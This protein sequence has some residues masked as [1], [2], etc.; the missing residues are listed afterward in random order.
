MCGRRVPV[1]AV[2]TH[3]SR[4]AFMQVAAGS[5]ALLALYSLTSLTTLLTL[6]FFAFRYPLKKNGQWN[7]LPSLPTFRATY[8]HRLLFAVSPATHAHLSSDFVAAIH[9]LFYKHA[10]QPRFSY[11]LSAMFEIS[12]KS[13]VFHIVWWS[14]A[15]ATI[16][17]AQGYLLSSSKDILISQ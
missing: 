12:T 17:T 9:L 6:F 16:G 8:L 13:P 2:H 7:A 15:E 14:L 4:F 5:Y 11:P 10:M 1:N 3:P